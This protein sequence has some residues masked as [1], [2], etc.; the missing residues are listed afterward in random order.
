MVLDWQL[1]TSLIRHWGFESGSFLFTII[2]PP[3]AESYLIAQYADPSLLAGLSACSAIIHFLIKLSESIG[4]ASLSL[5]GRYN[6]A[7]RYEECGEVMYSALG[8]AVGYG[9]LQ[10]VIM[11]Y[12][13]TSLLSLV[14][15]CASSVSASLYLLLRSKALIA[16]LITSI[17]FN[18]LKIQSRTDKVIALSF[19]GSAGYL[20]SA[21]YLIPAYGLVGAGYASLLQQ[22]LVIFFSFL[23]LFHDHSFSRYFRARL[24]LHSL[25]HHSRNI[26]QLCLPII[27]DKAS[28]A[29]AYVWLTSCISLFGVTALASY[30]IVKTIGRSILLPIFGLANSAGFLISNAVGKK[31]TNA[32]TSLFTFFISLAL[33]ASILSALIIYWHALPLIAYFSTRSDITLFVLPL[34]KWALIG[35]IAD[36]LQLLLCAILRAAGK[37][38]IVMKTR[39]LLL[40]CAF[41]PLSLAVTLF[42]KN[43]LFATILLYSAFY[44]HTALASIW[45]LRFIWHNKYSLHI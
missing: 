40:C 4:V 22:V 18:L 13:S 24:S 6:G 32:L 36:A 9:I 28:V 19:I 1:F 7:S 43:A 38:V 23:T 34:L 2:L 26:A 16:S 33:S 5:M 12:A 11:Y 10:Y 20:I 17:L 30:E 31:D 25:I 3:L 27:I 39:L 35:G 15:S 41:L 44:L 29:G 45:L 42:L 21:F 8:I 37:V 14:A